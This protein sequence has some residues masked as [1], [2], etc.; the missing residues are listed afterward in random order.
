MQH[1]QVSCAVRHIYIYIYIY[2][3]SRLRVKHNL[4]NPTYRTDS[5][6]PAGL[7]ILNSI[8][9]STTTYSH[10]CRPNK[11]HSGI[12][13]EKGTGNAKAQ[14]GQLGHSR[15]IPSYIR[16]LA[17]Y[18]WGLNLMACTPLLPLASQ[19]TVWN[20]SLSGFYIHNDHTIIIILQNWAM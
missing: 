5:P 19:W 12:V 7:K 8:S 6:A 20:H 14:H 11:T 3:V 17:Q 15:S 9:S 1:L 16:R 13:L 10:Q 2:V 4:R 18:P